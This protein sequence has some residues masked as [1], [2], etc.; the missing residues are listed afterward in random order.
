[1]WQTVI[2]FCLLVKL[3]GVRATCT[4][5][6]V[7]VG[8]KCLF[9]ATMA[10]LQHT[11]ARQ[12]CHSMGGELAAVL[13]A[14]QFKDIVDYIYNNG[15]DGQNFWLDGTDSAAEG[16]WQTSA[17]LPLPMGTPFWETSYD[18]EEPNNQGNENCLHISPERSYYMNDKS[19]DA[20]FSPLC[21]E[22]AVSSSR[23]GTAP[24]SC[25]MP[26][27]EFAGLCLAFI[28]WAD[29][30]WAEARQTCHGLSGELAALTDVEQL[31]AVYLYLH[32]ESIAYDSFWLGGSDIEQ[33]GSWKWT[34][35]EP[36]TMG[37]P[38]WGF[39]NLSDG[40]QPQGGTAE[41]CLYLDAQAGHYFFDGQ[42]DLLLNPLCMLKGQ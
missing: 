4:Y 3:S 13:T 21:E 10:D 1:M 26:Y 37:T 11:E 29:Q 9:F 28:T 2:T 39:K 41:N 5:P 38:F 27:M 22:D 20:I 23:N 42:C 8:E 18:N 30:G 16:Q 7:A 36:V 12:M 14:T 17:G 33:E 19:C 31:R 35:G 6:Y 40:Q 32:Q 34:D 24:R 15:Y 25:P